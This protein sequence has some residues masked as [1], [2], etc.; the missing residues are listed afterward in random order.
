MQGT[1]LLPVMAREVD[2]VNDAIFA[3][4]T[5]HAAYEPIRA[6]R[7][8]RWKYIRRFGDRLRPVLA[9]VDDSPTKDLL[10][11]SGW[12]DRELDRR[13]AA[14]PALRPRRVAEPRSS[15]S[16][17]AEVG[18]RD[19]RPAGRL[20]GRATDD[21]LRHGPVPAPE[22]AE[23]NSPDQISPAEPANGH[24]HGPGRVSALARRR[25]RRSR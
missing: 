6:V 21:P 14:R 3:E 22:G 9:N 20:D 15:G 16:I 23:L 5:Y 18:R 7:T 4:L 11:S 13:G 2:E 12:A 25:G 17:H 10:L 24:V 1:S 19:A 8:A